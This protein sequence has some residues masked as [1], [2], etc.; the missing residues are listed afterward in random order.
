MSMCG[1]EDGGVWWRKTDDGRPGWRSGGWLV[2]RAFVRAWFEV[3]LMARATLRSASAISEVTCSCVYLG[4]EVKSSVNSERACKFYR[5][6]D[7]SWLHTTD[8]CATAV[9]VTCTS[10]S[11]DDAA[12]Q[13]L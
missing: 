12:Q 10:L 4:S 13:R 11:A 5:C 6:C 2:K 3:R 7:S 9:L 8:L 1:L